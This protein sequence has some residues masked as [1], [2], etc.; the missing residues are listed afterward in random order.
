MTLLVTEFESGAL[1]DDPSSGHSW[2]CD[3]DSV[4]AK[5]IGIPTR[6]GPTR[7]GLTGYR[8]GRGY[9]G[10]RTCMRCAGLERGSRVAGI[11]GLGTFQ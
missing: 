10:T 5:C 1:T 6:V 9:P 4:S 3:S 11:R 2:S 7:E 8:P